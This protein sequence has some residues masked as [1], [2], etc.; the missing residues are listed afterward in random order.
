MIKTYS[1][2]KKAYKD[3]RLPEIAKT[4]KLWF[5]FFNNKDERIWQ[6][7]S[8]QAP[9]SFEERLQALEEY[10]HL[11]EVTGEQWDSNWVFGARK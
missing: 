6:D 7:V 1:Q 8:I 10:E 3:N 11:Y 2:L 4:D 9:Q 5:R